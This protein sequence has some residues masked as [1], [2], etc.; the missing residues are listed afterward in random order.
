MV[1]TAELH[2]ERNSTRDKETETQGS[3]KVLETPAYLVERTHHSDGYHLINGSLNISLGG[4]LNYINICRLLFDASYMYLYR[5]DNREGINVFD[6]H[7][8]QASPTRPQRPQGQRRVCRPDVCIPPLS[9]DSSLIL[10]TDVRSFH[11]DTT[12]VVRGNSECRC[13]SDGDGRPHS[14]T[15]RPELC[16]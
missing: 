16:T 5:N 8:A 1:C 12:P 14:P 2:L 4:L 7:A 6:D 10:I 9:L 11:L 15:A 13:E 3:R